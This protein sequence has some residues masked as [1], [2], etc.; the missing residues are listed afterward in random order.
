MNMK[1]H[2]KNYLAALC[3]ALACGSVGTASAD[4]FKGSL[5]SKPT[6]TD[7]IEVTCTSSDAALRVDAKI[8]DVTPVKPPRLQVTVEKRDQKFTA[9]DPRD[10]DGIYSPWASAPGGPGAYTITVSKLVSK[11]GKPDRTRG[12]AEKY[13]LIS[14]CMVGLEHPDTYFR[15]IQN[16]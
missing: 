16:R 8:N 14:H 3:A 15:Y 13:V 7:I 1:S 5:G 12:H 6:A 11:D 4:L 10:G 2:T 9:I